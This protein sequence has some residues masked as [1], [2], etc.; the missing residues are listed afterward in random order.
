VTTIAQAGASGSA[1]IH[2]RLRVSSRYLTLIQA[3]GGLYC[4]LQVTFSAP[5]QRVLSQVIPLTDRARAAHASRRL[6]HNA[7]RAAG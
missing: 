6:Q 5:G 3:K 2:L 7:H 4:L 1:E